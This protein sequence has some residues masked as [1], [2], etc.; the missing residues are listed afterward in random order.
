M[1][2]SNLLAKEQVKP[3]EVMESFLLL[4]SPLAPHMSEELWALLGHR[5]TLA[6]E[7]WPTYDPKLI[8]DDVIEIPIMVNGKVKSKIS[9][10]ADSIES[11]VEAQVMKD[12]KVLAAIQGKSIT[13]KKYVPKKIYTL[14]VN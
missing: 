13:Q 3:R 9:I 5:E 7:P 1:T 8:E 6:F 10:A 11:A 2:F 14:A 4:L 12:P